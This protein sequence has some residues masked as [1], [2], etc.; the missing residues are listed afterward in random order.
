MTLKEAVG[1]RVDVD[2]K[3]GQR[4]THSEVYGRIIDY[5]GGLK[6]VAP[7]IPF[8][9]PYLREKLKRDPWLNNTDMSKWDAAAG[10]RCSR[11]DC[12]A[13][14]GGL[15]ALYRSHGITGASCSDG[16]SLLKEA[17]RRL[18]EQSEVKTIDGLG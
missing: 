6:A 16:V 1:V 14:G 8:E 15:W 18:C 11:S 3:T 13:S 2:V 4:L 10:F 17:A 12:F 7:Y 9:I 5:L